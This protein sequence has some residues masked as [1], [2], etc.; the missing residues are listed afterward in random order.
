MIERSQV[1]SVSEDEEGMRLDRWIKKKFPDISVKKIYSANGA[2]ERAVTY[3]KK[4]PN[5]K[6]G[7]ARWP[8]L[9]ISAYLK[10]PSSDCG[11]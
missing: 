5:K 9:R 2:A 3:K 1:F 8:T 7:R 11:L 6:I 4:Y 10:R